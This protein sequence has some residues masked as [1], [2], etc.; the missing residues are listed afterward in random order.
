MLISPYTGR[1]AQPRLAF[2]PVRWSRLAHAAQG[3]TGGTRTLIR[4]QS[5][6]ALRHAYT[7]NAP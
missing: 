6:S 7:L 4:P 1:V 5:G 3:T 2:T